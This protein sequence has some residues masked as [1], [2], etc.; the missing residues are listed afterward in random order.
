M[1]ISPRILQLSEYRNLVVQAIESEEIKDGILPCVNAYV[2][3]KNGLFLNSP[4]KTQTLTL[5]Y[6]EFGVVSLKIQCPDSI[7][8]EPEFLSILQSISFFS[9]SQELLVVKP[10]N[11]EKIWSSYQALPRGIYILK[12][13]SMD[14]L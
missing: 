7:K 6:L 13:S 1:E 11:E 12:D 14:Q 8:S 3:S 9:D 4:K 2:I 10:V 5:N